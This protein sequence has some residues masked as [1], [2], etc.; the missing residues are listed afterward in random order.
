MHLTRTSLNFGRK[1]GHPEETQADTVRTCKLRT[2]SDPS[3]E[4]NPGPWR[5]EAAVLTTVPPFH[6]SAGII[7][8]PVAGFPVAEATCH[9]LP[10]AHRSQR[11]FPLLTSYATKE[12]AKEDHF[13]RDRIIPQVGRAGKFCPMSLVIKHR[14]ASAP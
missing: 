1:P 8:L 4:S 9:W 5:C 3:W 14:M 10:A 2:D 12:P 7:T 6:P 13:Q 11:P